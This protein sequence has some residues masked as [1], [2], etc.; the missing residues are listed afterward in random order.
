MIKK[1]SRRDFIKTAALTTIALTTTNI[2]ARDAQAAKP[3][4]AKTRYGTY[5]GFVGKRG[6][7][8]WL[9]I[10]YAKPPVGNLRWRAPEPLTPSDKTFDAKKFGCS[11]MQDRDEVEPASLLPQ[12]EDCL[13]LN[14]FTRGAAKNLPV[15]V[16]IP[17]G[18]FVSG[19]SGDPAYNGTNFAASHDVLVVTI[20]Y[21]LNVF[22]F[23]NFAGIDSAFEDTGYLGIKDQIAALT[24]VKE[25]IASFGGDP[26]NVTVFGESAGSISIMFLTVTPAAQG[27]FGKAIAQSGNIAFCNKPQESATLAADFM[28]LSGC[29]NINELMNKPAAELIATY[30][31]LVELRPFADEV[32]YLPTCD[33]KFLPASPLRALKDGAA[34]GIKLLTGTTVEEY[35]YWALYYPN[36]VEK[37]RHMHAALNPINGE[38]NFSIN[39]IYRSWAKNH[40]DIAD[41]NERY[42][43]F[44]NQL[45][46]RVG[47]ELCA[48]YQAAFDD[49]YFYLF[50]QKASL[51]DL[52]SCHAVDLP[53]VFGNPTHDIDLHPSKRLIK[54]VQTAWA[55]FAATGNPNNEFIPN[56]APYSA[57]DRQTMEIN[58]KAWTCHKNLNVD[59]MNELRGAYENYLLA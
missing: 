20:N 59:N 25:N 8:T 3:C 43:E 53:F 44:A 1:I 42:F 55:S 4:T 29:K 9:G 6:V 21:R 17:G 26:D 52:G 12:S 33:G 7:Q 14:I 40:A 10:P 27:L 23:M 49:V 30:E 50:S 51:N 58:A 5:N 22:G 2:F 47:Q 11:P 41:E 24:W 34:R 28:D 48:E 16:F 45:D 57:V 46:W 15:M 35:R 39:E 19:G 32:G 36:L 18:G 37:M 31:K 54:Q 56:W 13:T 38:E